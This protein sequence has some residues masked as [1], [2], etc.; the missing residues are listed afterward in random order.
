MKAKP[1]KY[2]MGGDLNSPAIPVVAPMAGQP[3]Q[4]QVPMMP[5]QPAMAKGGMAK[6]YAK[7]GMVNCGASVPPAQKSKK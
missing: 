7:G 6:G 4:K 5:V 3:M 2:A 1:K